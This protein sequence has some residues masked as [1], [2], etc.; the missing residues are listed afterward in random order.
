MFDPS[1]DASFPKGMSVSPNRNPVW[2]ADLSE[3]TFGIRELRPK[4]KESADAKSDDP[5]AKPKPDD[6]PDLPDMVIWHYKDSRLQ[7]MQQVQENADKN[8]SFL[9]A[10][11]PADQKFMRLGDDDVRVVSLTPD[12]K[13]AL[14]TDIRSYE[15]DSHFE[16]TDL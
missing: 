5:D 12:S 10:Y 4:K 13:Y 14:G 2:M 16:R 9:C 11:R 1:K 7:P 8:F 3:V 15:L 6:S